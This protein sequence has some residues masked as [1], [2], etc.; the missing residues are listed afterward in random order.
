M[1]LILEPANTLVYQIVPVFAANAEGFS[2]QQ[3]RSMATNETR[4]Q[5]TN[6]RIE[7]PTPLLNHPVHWFT[8]RTRMFIARVV[9]QN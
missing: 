9:P 6:E 1:S 2:V 7:P 5:C 4:E 8:T 3:I